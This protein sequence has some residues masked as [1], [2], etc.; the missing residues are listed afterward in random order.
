LMIWTGFGVDAEAE[1]SLD[2]TTNEPCTDLLPR[3]ST[4][5]ANDFRVIYH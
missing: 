4:R 5:V 3:I 1:P 2:A